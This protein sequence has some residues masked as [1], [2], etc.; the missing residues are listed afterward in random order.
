MI[1]R[2]LQ[3]PGAVMRLGMV[4]LVLASISK[5]ALRRSGWLPEDAADFVT[6]LAYGISIATLLWSMALR[7]K[8]QPRP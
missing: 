7:R 2:R 5:F 8:G 6:G 1:L 4:F 3:T